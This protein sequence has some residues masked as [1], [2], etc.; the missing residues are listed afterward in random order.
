M[1]DAGKQYDA[2][3]VDRMLART[4]PAA[5]AAVSLPAAEPTAAPVTVAAASLP[6]DVGAGA[7]SAG[8]SA[9]LQRL[10]RFVLLRQ[11][12]EGGMGRVYAAYDEEL[13]RKVALKVLHLNGLGGSEGR[14]R[15]LREAQA[16]ARV[17]HPN[18]VP[19]YS[20]GE[21][22]GELFIA[23]EFVDGQT[24]YE[25]QRQP[26][27]AGEIL[28]MYQAAG[29]GL[30]AAHQAG[31]VHR[32]FKPENVLVGRYG[33]PR[34]ADF[35]LARSELPAGLPATA[36]PSTPSPGTPSGPQ[37]TALSVDGHLVGTPAYMAP[38]Q[39]RG[40]TAD[41]RSDQYSF[42]VALYEALYRALPFTGDSLAELAAN[43]LAGRRR[44]LAGDSGPPLG[45]HAGGELPESI[46][47]AVERGLSVDPSAR[48]PSMAELLT[49]LSVDPRHSPAAGGSLRRRFSYGVLV[50]LLFMLFFV[51]VMRSSGQLTVGA[52]AA[53]G[54][55]IYLLMIGL[56][57]VLRKSLAQNSFHRG[58]VAMFLCAVS[59]VVSL[60]WASFYVGLRLEQLAPL[61]LLSIG[62]ISALGSYRFYRAG[63]LISGLCFLCSLIC[64][65]FPQHTPQIIS[66]SYPVIVISIISIWARAGR[67]PV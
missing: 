36:P 58:M 22:D 59:C 3:L 16:M 1:G 2:A 63:W 65:A 27:S 20:V 53:G 4:L 64:L 25:W 18:V 42:C 11:L 62:F 44:A 28:S 32:D 6:A 50:G 37:P 21:F 61:D 45:P 15:V 14:T 8:Q 47:A 9:L 48:Y 56:A 31:L 40:Q 29:Q 13:D 24:L 12:G 49:A 66:V 54:T 10:G 39:Y 46:V 38:E 57:I 55:V 41:A 30:L 67:R 52:I 26:R 17:S 60:R 43:V 5:E 7:S 23:M 35:G 33:R 19:V 34:V 51:R